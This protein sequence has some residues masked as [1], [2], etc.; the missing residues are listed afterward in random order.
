VRRRA[1]QRKSMR[2]PRAPPGS[3]A[4]RR[5]GGGAVPRTRLPFGVN[6]LPARCWQRYVPANPRGVRLSASAQRYARQ[7]RHATGKRAGS[8]EAFYRLLRAAGACGAGGSARAA[9]VRKVGQQAFGYVAE[10]GRTKRRSM[11]RPIGN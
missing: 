2:E 5:A 6:V 10:R 3:C 9:A 11:S 1:L 4:C 7:V 8:A